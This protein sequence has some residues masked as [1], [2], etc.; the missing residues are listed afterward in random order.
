MIA[1]PWNTLLYLIIVPGLI[2]LFRYIAAK[3]SKPIPIGVVQGI[4]AVLAVS[5]VFLNGGF[6]GL[7]IPVYAGDPVGFVGAWL[8]LLVAAWGPVELLYR[9]VWKALYEKVGLA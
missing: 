6:A 8:T 1:E 9:V 3:S 5:F 4:A 7:G 2:Q